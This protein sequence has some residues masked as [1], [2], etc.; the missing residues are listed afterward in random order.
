[1]VQ[2]KRINTLEPDFKTLVEQLD[3]ELF[4]RYPE[5]QQ[6]YA[7][8]NKIESI[9]TSVIA[10]EFDNPVACG[11]FKIYSSDSVEIKRMYVN[12]TARGRGI[13]KMILNEL[14][15]W[16]REIGFKKAIL[17]TGSNQPEA[18]GLYTKEG[19]IKIENFAPYQ[20]MPNSICFEKIL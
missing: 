5:I 13:S 9:D 11:C 12:P 3:I 15:K 16:A 20:N 8:L 18:I 7:P 10:Y 6:I 17:E 1:M 14:L 19:F 2:I 4:N